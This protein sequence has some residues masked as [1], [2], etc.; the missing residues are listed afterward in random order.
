MTSSNEELVMADG[1]PTEVV[2]SSFGHSVTVSE[3]ADV[4][5]YL[6][7]V[8]RVLRYHVV[9]MT[10]RAGSGH[11]GGSLSAADIIATLYF[12]GVLNHRPMD[13]EW[14]ERDRFVLSKGHA[15]P[16][17]YA[18]LAE[19]GYFDIKDLLKLRKVGSH[20]QGHTD[21][22]VT[23]GVEMSSGS[24]GQGLSFGVGL[25]LGA[26]LNYS[27][28]RIFVLLGDGECDE[29]QVWEA[30]M[31]AA[32]FGLDNLTAIID[33]N[34]LQ[35]DGETEC[36]MKLEPFAD[37]WSSFGWHVKEI[38][39]HDIKQILNAFNE[40]KFINDKPT[41]IIAHTIKGQGVKCME[42]RAEWHGKVLSPDEA[43]P[44]LK[45]LRGKNGTRIIY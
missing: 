39:G 3:R 37:K 20:L 45:D 1:N 8:A 43:K 42:G 16:V 28:S 35:I 18:A 31:S 4:Y 29:G 23:P 24:L 13:P 40:A 7:D 19:C 9:G 36:V 30:A 10:T 2:E 5:S 34:G 33:R 44:I 25:G 11:P 14:A 38:D 6:T 21:S 15:A 26:K 12:G 41:A 27:D 17:L 22:T 32:H